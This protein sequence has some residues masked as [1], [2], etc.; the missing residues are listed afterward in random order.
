MTKS[1]GFVLQFF[2]IFF[3]RQSLFSICFHHVIISL[4][5]S[6]DAWNLQT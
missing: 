6:V 5:P 2:P 4:I 1:R 3:A